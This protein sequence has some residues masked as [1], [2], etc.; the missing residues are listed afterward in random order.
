MFK[1]GEQTNSHQTSSL[2]GQLCKGYL[3]W[4]NGEPGEWGSKLIFIY[5]IICLP[6]FAKAS[7][8]RYRSEAIRVC[9]EYRK[10]S[11]THSTLL[12]KVQPV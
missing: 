6:L 2:A 11:N 5:Y 8:A 3:N 12:E 9:S 4:P 10:H 1:V 7:Q